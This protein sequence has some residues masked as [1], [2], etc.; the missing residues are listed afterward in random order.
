MPIDIMH[1]A[2]RHGLIAAST[3][4][5][6]RRPR[7]PL[8]VFARTSAPGS[9][10]PSAIAWTT[11]G[12]H[13][14]SQE[15]RRASLEHGE[16]GASDDGCVHRAWHALLSG[17]PSD[18][19]LSA[20]GTLQHIPRAAAQSARTARERGG[21]RPRVDASVRWMTSTAA[22]PSSSSRRHRPRQHSTLNANANALPLLL[23]HPSDLDLSATAVHVDPPL[24]TSPLRL[25]R[26]GPQPCLSFATSELRGL[27]I[28]CGCPSC[29]AENF[30]NQK[31][32]TDTPD[33]RSSCEARA[34]PS[35]QS[36]PK[37]KKKGGGEMG[38]PARIPGR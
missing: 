15:D 25:H 13:L 32:T 36:R 9:N 30:R 38:S 26:R 10:S 19:E 35:R 12:W 23:L 22:S 6:V 24:A 1:C 28:R 2:V 16:E 5:Q 14:H 4:M 11:D 34:T 33:T 21:R 17:V 27:P 18:G 37:Q 31:D 29:P 3:G 7:E 20:P 8:R